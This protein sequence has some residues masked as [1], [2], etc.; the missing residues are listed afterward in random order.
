MTQPKIEEEKN[1]KKTNTPKTVWT[2][3]HFRHLPSESVVKLFNSENA[4]RREFE[5]QVMA[6]GPAKEYG[7]TYEL[8]K[9]SLYYDDGEN[10]GEISIFESDIY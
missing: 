6:N 8:K 5:K 7:E 3:A 10:W 1:M 9:D 4:A 2:V